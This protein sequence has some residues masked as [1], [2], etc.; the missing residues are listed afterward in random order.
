MKSIRGAYAERGVES[1]YRDE[2]HLYHNPHTA[3]V[4]ALLTRYADVISGASVL[5][6]CCGSG[7]VTRAAIELKAREVVGVDPYTYDAYERETGLTCL[8]Y[9]FA[10]IIGGALDAHRTSVMLDHIPHY[11]VVICSF[12]MHLC[13]LEQLYALTYTLFKY[14]EEVIIITPHKR[15]ELEL[16]S[17]VSLRESAIELTSKKKRVTLKRYI[18]PHHPERPHYDAL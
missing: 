16:I 15:P 1:F 5:D 6:L 13:P 4:E 14:T 8:R 11:D 3:Q 18:M 2:G 12:A 17:G 10:E 7:E 9:N